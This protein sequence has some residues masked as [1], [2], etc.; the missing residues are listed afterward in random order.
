MTGYVLELARK[1]LTDTR[2]TDTPQRALAEGEARLKIDAFALTANNVTYA[3]FGEAMKYWDFFPPSD[4][5]HGRVPVWGFADVVESRAEG[6]AVGQRVYGYFPMGTELI[7][8]PGRIG[9]DGFSDIAPHRQHLSPI[10]NRYTVTKTDLAYQPARE[11]EQMLYRPLFMTAFLLDD[12][13]AEHSPDE[14]DQL[15]LSSA[16][17][18]T[19]FA[20]AAL[21]ASRGVRVVGLTSRG[22][23]D[24]VTGLGVYGEVI[25]YDD[26]RTLSPDQ[27]VYVDFMGNAAIT[28]QVHDR[29]GDALKLSLVVGATDWDAPRDGAPTSGPRPV[30]FFAPDQGQKRNKEWGSERFARNIAAALHTFFD[31]SEGW[32]KIE[33]VNGP[34][35]MARAWKETVN[36]KVAPDRGIIVRP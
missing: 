19:A 20:L 31:R 13:I 6:V 35:A 18:K 11:A 27:S 34:D 10:Y 8:S 26:I 1:G 2:K 25:A 5:A 23:V 14:K 24:F 28:R 33:T 7:V 3:A 12:L 21:A 4:A 16:S 17:S 36:G 15:V 30:F 9:P 32:L 29:L 22:N